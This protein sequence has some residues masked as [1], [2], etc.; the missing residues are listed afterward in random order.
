MKKNKSVANTG[1]AEAAGTQAIMA[2]VPDGIYEF[3]CNNPYP[4]FVRRYC[5][6]MVLYAVGKASDFGKDIIMYHLKPIANY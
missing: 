6:E 3:H 1:T 2:I 5:M 4:I